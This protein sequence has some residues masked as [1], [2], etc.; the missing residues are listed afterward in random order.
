MHLVVHCHVPL[1][2]DEVLASNSN[3]ICLC[4]NLSLVVKRQFLFRGNRIFF[5]KKICLSKA[6]ALLF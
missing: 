3:F 6:C 1:Y 5:S 2:L 4:Q